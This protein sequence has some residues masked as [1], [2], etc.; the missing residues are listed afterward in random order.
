[1]KPLL[2]SVYAILLLSVGLTAC[3][4][5]D[6]TTLRPHVV[7]LSN[8]SGDSVEL[9][10]GA[11][12][13]VQQLSID[14]PEAGHLQLSAYGGEP[15]TGVTDD[16]L[17]RS[18]PQAF[19]GVGRLSAGTPESPAA[20]LVACCEDQPFPYR[21]SA[22]SVGATYRIEEAGTY[23]YGVFALRHPY[24]GTSLRPGTFTAIFI[25]D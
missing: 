6:E 4:G 24:R 19:I 17:E 18:K 13:V 22:Y 5:G 16:I 10:E 7:P 14:V 9:K 8:A 23:Q 2:I 11:W 20:F 15:V 3:S 21:V 1:M 25:P 12:T